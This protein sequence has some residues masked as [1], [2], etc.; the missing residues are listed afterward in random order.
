MAHNGS[1]VA[2]PGRDIFAQAL[3]HKNPIPCDAVHRKVPSPAAA[4]TPATRR[5]R[6]GYLPDN[7][8]RRAS[9]GRT[10]SHPRAVTRASFGTESGRLALFPA[11]PVCQTRADRRICP[12]G[13]HDAAG[14]AGLLVAAISGFV[15]RF[16]Q[17][18]VIT[19][20]DKQNN[21]KYRCSHENHGEYGHVVFLKASLVSASPRGGDLPSRSIP[22]ARQRREP[23]A[24]TVINSAI[25][26]IITIHA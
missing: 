14:I 26:P 2:V 5:R 22:A 13:N 25:V 17:H 6:A 18:L 3:V 8:R 15:T 11:R 1:V 9:T 20:C 19:P 24:V 12:T 4:A 16:P 23:I 10:C 21:E 7:H